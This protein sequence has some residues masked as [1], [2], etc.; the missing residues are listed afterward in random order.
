MIA[1]GGHWLILTLQ[2]LVILNASMVS[3]QTQSRKLAV[4]IRK[5]YLAHEVSGIFLN[6]PLP[7]MHCVTLGISVYRAD[8]AVS[9]LRACELFMNKIPGI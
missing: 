9:H 6:N 2:L 8:T 4:A 5:M 7:Y 1:W 3:G